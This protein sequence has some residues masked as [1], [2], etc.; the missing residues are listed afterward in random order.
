MRHIAW[1]AW[2][3]SPKIPPLLTPLGG[4]HRWGSCW[5][6]D[7]TIHRGTAPDNRR[8]SGSRWRNHSSCQ[9]QRQPI[10]RSCTEKDR[11]MSDISRRNE[12]TSPLLEPLQVDVIEAARLLRYSRATIY[13][14][15]SRGDLPS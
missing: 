5:D 9:L 4:L 13:E 7:R 1:Y 11:H 12:T 3:L 2:L 10:P 6:N 8:Q 15:L 14:M